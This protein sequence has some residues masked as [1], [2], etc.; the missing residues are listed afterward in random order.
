MKEAKAKKWER[1]GER[2][3]HITKVNIMQLTSST[4]FASYCYVFFATV[5]V[6]IV[7]II[8]S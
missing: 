8:T 6:D 4:H 3:Y 7:Y 1:P 5:F 2:L